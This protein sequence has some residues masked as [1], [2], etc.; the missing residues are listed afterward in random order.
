MKRTG[1]VGLLAAA[2]MVGAVATAQ[3]QMGY[4]PGYGYGMGP[5][6]MGGYGMG[7]GMMFGGGPFNRPV[8][9]GWGGGVLTYPKVSAYLHKSETLGVAN[10]KA[11]TVTFSGKTIE[12]DM[13]AVQPGHDDQTFEVHGLTNPTLVVPQG[14]V[15]HMNLVNM[16]YGD[17]MEHG[18]IITPAAPPYPWMAMM[19]TG[20]GLAGVMP[21]LPW[22]STKNLQTAHYA[23]LGAK[24]VARQAGTYW[25]VCPTPKHAMKGMYGKFVVE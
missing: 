1:L 8:W 6:M 24:F 20:P 4:G 18:V 23:A 3:A 25:Y 19:A 2:A 9:P 14:A 21:L 16:D 10:P 22:R 15:I 13:V 5:G 17:T 12:I 7:P 11:N